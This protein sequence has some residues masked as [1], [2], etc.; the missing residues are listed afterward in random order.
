MNLEDIVRVVFVCCSGEYEAYLDGSLLS[1][2][3][4]GMKS[5]QLV[6]ILTRYML[7]FLFLLYARMY[8]W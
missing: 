5:W 7:C 4:T 1:G 8:I 6:M 3:H 2:I